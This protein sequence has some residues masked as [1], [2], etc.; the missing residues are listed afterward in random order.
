VEQ[1]HDVS[2]FK[3]L[4][5]YAL[6]SDGHAHALVQDGSIDWMCAPQPDAPPLFARILDPYAGHFALLGEDHGY[7]GDTFAHRSVTESGVTAIDAFD[8]AAQGMRLVRRFEGEGAVEIEFAP[9]LDF[10]RHATRLVRDEAGVRI[11]DSAWRVAAPLRS[12]DIVDVGVH[13]TARLV[14]DAPAS[15]VLQHAGAP[16]ARPGPVDSRRFTSWLDD[17]RLP[18]HRLAKR[19]ALVLGALVHPPTGA[20]VA[21]PTTS[22][23]EVIGHGRNW[24]YRYCWPRDTAYALRVLAECGSRGEGLAFLSWLRDR[25]A[26]SS[27]RPIYTLRGEE[28]GPD[29]PVDG[30]GGH[31]GSAPVRTGNSAADQVQMDVFG[32]VLELGEGLC[33]DGER[34]ADDHLGL[35]LRLADAVAEAWDTPG[36]GI[37]EIRG[38]AT[39]HTYSLAM[40][41]SALD[42]ARRIAA[43][44]R[45]ADS[46]QAARDAIRRR[47]DAMYSVE[48]GAW[49]IGAGSRYL[50]AAVLRAM[51]CGV[52]DPT[53]PRVRSTIDVIERDLA[54]AHGV[55]RY[56]MPDGLDGEEGAFHLCTAWMS[57]A[58]ALVGQRD[59]A[60][61]WL[62]V[63]ANGA[64]AAG[65]IPEMIDVATGQGLGNT[66]QAYSHLGLLSAAARLEA[67]PRERRD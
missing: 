28:V 36:Q 56:R 5:D 7:D 42:S 50:D 20:M 46:W 24:D 62:E 48:L 11:E 25:F 23:P 31:R 27:L 29:V 6:L 10:G 4:E 13:Q 18:G 15:V 59:E 61:R 64:G 55:Y 40:C 1:E 65:M 53:D 51:T 44:H 49:P 32:P 47:L 30:L 33:R 37:W 41:W 39:H 63:L 58:R 16:E 57:E 19:S 66:P 9:R 26:T 67:S 2:D 54:T 17:L 38:P 8:P 45:R 52:F 12:C 21:A 35:M 3:P 43:R 14:V 34:L 60:A 22:L